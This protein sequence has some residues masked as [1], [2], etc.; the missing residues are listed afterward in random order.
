MPHV[1]HLL[2]TEEVREKGVVS[3]LNHNFDELDGQRTIPGEAY[4]IKIVDRV[5]DYMFWNF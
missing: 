3:S 4:T 5:T 2:H 1:L